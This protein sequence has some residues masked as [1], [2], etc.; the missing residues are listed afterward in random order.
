MRSRYRV[1]I[2]ILSLSNQ[3]DLH[4]RNNFLKNCSSF[5]YYLI[6]WRERFVSDNSWWRFL[7]FFKRLL[8]FRKSTISNSKRSIRNWIRFWI[9][10]MYFLLR[11][12]VFIFLIIFLRFRSTL[13]NK[14]RLWRLIRKRV[15]STRFINVLNF[16]TN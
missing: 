11:R 15:C 16:S 10:K 6:N 8:R 4:S 7:H 5:L 14:S 12:H 9:A 1:A 13:T 3:S 2:F